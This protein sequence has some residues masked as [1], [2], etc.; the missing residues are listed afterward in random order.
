M[1]STVR[2]DLERSLAND[3]VFTT[4]S[5]LRCHV[6][7]LL[8]PSLSDGDNALT[9]AVHG[10]I[11]DAAE[12]IA[13]ISPLLQ[14]PPHAT[15]EVDEG[16]RTDGNY[17]RHVRRRRGH[18]MSS[19]TDGMTAPRLHRSRQRSIEL[20]AS[21]DVTASLHYVLFPSQT[22]SPTIHT[23]S[24]HGR[25]RSSMHRPTFIRTHM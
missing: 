22:Y 9:N 21:I 24:L 15:S 23:P 13:P 8:I 10:A 12:W 18:R 2:R 3:V 4:Q 6:L 25:R 7:R 1:S 5:R 19:M 17:P 16:R 11:S 14:A 20:P